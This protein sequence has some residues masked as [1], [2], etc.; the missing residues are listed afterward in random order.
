MV[1][2]DNGGN[3]RVQSLFSCNILLVGF[4][5]TG[6]STISSYLVKALG[7]EEIDTD[8]LIEQREGRSIANIFETDGEAYFRRCE[9]QLLVELQ[10]RKNLIISCGGGM[11]LQDENVRLMK[12]TGKIVLLTARPET[13]YERVKDSR[14]RPLLNHNMN[15]EFIAGLLEKRRP[16]YL[17]AADIIIDT[18]GRDVS[19]ICEELIEKV[20]GSTK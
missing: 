1:N 15:V 8:R 5:G 20:A 12:E 2:T 6:K 4:M 13:I 9:T 10:K 18:D 11:A 3:V 17:K 7:V 14:D 16:K 19:D